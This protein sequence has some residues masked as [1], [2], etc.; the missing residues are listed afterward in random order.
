M[1]EPK[2]LCIKF[3]INFNS[4]KSFSVYG[5][6]FKRIKK[7]LE[8]GYKEESIIQTVTLFEVLFS[9][10][11]KA[12]KSGW[13]S[14]F[15]DLSDQEKIEYRKTMR[16][17]LE[18]MKLYDEYLRNY[19]V[20]QETIPNPEIESLYETLFSNSK[21]RKIN[22]QN[23]NGKNGVKEAY[24]IFFKFDI[25]KELD[26]DRKEAQKKWGLLNK[27][28]KERHKIIHNGDETTLT[29]QQ[30]KEILDSIDFL[31]QRLEI[32]LATLVVKNI[33]KNLEP[34]TKGEAKWEFH[35]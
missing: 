32:Q 22:F 6:L 4:L 3:D 17:Y 10:C 1:S 27:F 5:R 24:L 13:L 25:S 15:S 18:D 8:K 30:I 9:D 33:V 20:Y 21:L 26:R 11:F 29:P 31:K 2:T 12:F 14:H 16:E 34:I 19:R 23:L 28:F 7:L 35:R